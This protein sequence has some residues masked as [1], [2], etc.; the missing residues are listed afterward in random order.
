MS[1]DS[2]F[3][4]LPMKS[5]DCLVPSEA[6]QCLECLSCG[7]SLTLSLPAHGEV[8]VPDRGMDYSVPP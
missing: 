6:A 2:L 7:L 3:E 8:E 5:F 4:G 1:V